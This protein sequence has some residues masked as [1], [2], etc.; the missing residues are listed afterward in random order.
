MSEP[1]FEALAKAKIN[2]TLHVG[3]VI[4]DTGDRFY[5]YHPLDSLV[6]FA[7]SAD[8][9]TVTRTSKST[10]SLSITGPF[11]AL[12]NPDDPSNLILKAYHAVKRHGPLPGL[13]FALTKNLPVASG[14][15]GGSADAAAALRLMKHFV[16]LS[17]AQWTDIAV[18]LGAD[19]LVCLNQQ[20]ARMTGVGEC[21][22]PIPGLGT[23]SAVLVNPKVSVST[24]QV[25]KAF[26]RGRPKET[27]RPQKSSGSLIERACEGRNDLEPVSQSLAPEI[28]LVLKTLQHSQGCQ[29]SRMSGSG[30]TCFGLYETRKAAKSAAQ[31][32][33]NQ[34]P[35]WWVQATQLGDA[36]EG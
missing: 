10:A 33:K 7:Q 31:T 34:Y 27:P 12:L 25:F 16:T 26:D 23:V 32:I 3:R 29:L 15:G 2:L 22:T 11:G 24:G 19:V 28:A 14:I 20:T 1:E 21:I 36:T 5:G 6:V 4:A 35:N 13:S 17:S 18:S 9:L 8:A 30:A